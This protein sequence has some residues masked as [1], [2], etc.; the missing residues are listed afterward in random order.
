MGKIKTKDNI[1]EST[2]V[3]YTDNEATKYSLLERVLE[4]SLFFELLEQRT[5]DSRRKKKDFKIVIKPNITMLLRR[6]DDGTYTD[7]FLVIHLLR[8]LLQKGYTN[9]TLVESQNFYGEWFT[10]RAVIQIA[11]RAGYFEESVLSSYNG[12][13]SRDV[14]IK[15]GGIDAYVPLVDLT[16]DMVPYD[17]GAPVG[18]IQLGGTWIE[19]DFRIN[20]AKMKTHFVCYNTL[21]IKNV[22]GCLPLQDKIREYHCKNALSLYTAHLIKAFP[23][24]FSLIDG[25]T[26]A[27]NVQGAKMKAISRKTHTIM[28]ST[29]ILAL[30]HYGASLMHQDP[31]KCIMFEELAGIMPRRPYKVIGNAV[32]FDPWINPNKL[33]VILSSRAQLSEKIMA[34]LGSLLTGGYDDCFPKKEPK[35]DIITRVVAYHRVIANFF[36]DLELVKLRFRETVFKRRL[37]K[38]NDLKNINASDSILSDL[39]F[40]SGKDIGRLIEILQD[41]TIKNLSF[42]GH[43]LFLNGREIPM[44]NRMTTSNLAAVSIM[45]HIQN[46][47]IDPG[48]FAKELRMMMNSYPDM[49]GSNHK[50]SYC[51]RA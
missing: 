35:K 19:A 13:R 28:G 27:D 30:D 9:L 20:F 4:E 24:D 38:K 33:A 49:F 8:L 7:P 14:H 12:E 2:V 44:P 25:Y 10:N 17:F 21:A 18:R 41:N 34:Y 32:N 16:L 22:Y 26:S 6:S 45:K 40:L 46:N 50:Y 3:A 15:G 37:K 1:D 43:Y 23:V 39:T 51:Y 48:T 5:K 11:A 47:S 42:S 29:D 31:E 36:S